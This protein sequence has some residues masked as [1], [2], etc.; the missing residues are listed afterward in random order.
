MKLLVSLA[1]NHGVAVTVRGG[2]EPTVPATDPMSLSQ[3]ILG[4]LL[5]STFGDSPHEEL[6]SEEYAL[7]FL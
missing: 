4:G 2:G 6:D 3:G 1:I 7:G 5:M